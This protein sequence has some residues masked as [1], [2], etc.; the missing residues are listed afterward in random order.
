M[1]LSSDPAQRVV[2]RILNANKSPMV[3]VVYGS[4]GCKN[5]YQGPFPETTKCVKCGKDARI[6]M[7]VREEGSGQD[8]GPYVTDLH[9][10]EP[11]KF[12]VHD[13]MATATYLC[14]DVNCATATTLWNQG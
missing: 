9:P 3:S 11:V 13:V 14:T 5:S 12:W 4:K 10:N 7:V 2:R 6:A 8:E 1:K